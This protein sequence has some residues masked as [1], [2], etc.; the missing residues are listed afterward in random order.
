M[1]NKRRVRREGKYW[2]NVSE[3]G[4]PA[5]TYEKQPNRK[6]ILKKTVIGGNKLKQNE[7]STEVDLLWAESPFGI[8]FV[9]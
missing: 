1:E 8:V 6:E 4:K 7:L 2:N 5:K 9:L 3:L